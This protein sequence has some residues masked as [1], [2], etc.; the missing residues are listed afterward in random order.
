MRLTAQH[1]L[2]TASLEFDKFMALNPKLRPYFRE[3]RPIGKEHELYNQAAAA[4]DMLLDVIDGNLDLTLGTASPADLA[5]WLITFAESFRRSPIMCEVFQDRKL[6]YSAKLREI[7]EK[8]CG[9]KAGTRPG[10]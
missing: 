2:L 4:A 5:E 9:G 10:G 8:G 3:D 6:E 1:Q 7:G